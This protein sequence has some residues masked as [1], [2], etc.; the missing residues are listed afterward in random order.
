MNYHSTY[1][2]AD[3]SILKVIW[4]VVFYESSRAILFTVQ[5]LQRTGI[6][7]YVRLFAQLYITRL[8]KLFHCS[9]EVQQT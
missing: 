4:K 1:L 5:P 7:L 2:L 6:V 9:E 8:Y 3:S